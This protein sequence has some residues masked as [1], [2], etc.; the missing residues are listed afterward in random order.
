MILKQE[1]KGG[2]KPKTSIILWDTVQ[3]KDGFAYSNQAL[4][5]MK[6]HRMLS[7]HKNTRQSKMLEEVNIIGN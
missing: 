7:F 6:E 1:G 3:I 2:T 4:G 5:T